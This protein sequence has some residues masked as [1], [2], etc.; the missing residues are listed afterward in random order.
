MI[1][2]RETR[3]EVQVEAE[4]DLFRSEHTELFASADALGAR[5]GRCSGG[6]MR[7]AGA[8]EL[9]AFLDSFRRRL[10][11]H[12]AA[13]ECDGMFDLAVAAAPRFERHVE[14]LRSEHEALRAGLAALGADAF[15]GS[16]QQFQ[17]RFT[18]FRRA[19][20]AHE[21]VENE[22]MQR[23]YLEDLGGGD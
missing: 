19:L 2:S 15:T 11:D 22:V 20:R 8:T 3:V 9:R 21:V 10:L 23:A 13:E 4:W 17:L 18:E 5:L 6:A 16:W 14:R 12:L 1:E 7:P